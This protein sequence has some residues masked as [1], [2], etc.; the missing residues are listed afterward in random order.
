MASYYVT[1]S[2]T[3]DGTGADAANTMS[4]SLFN[5]I[6]SFAAG[7]EVL[8]SGAFSTEIDI[9]L[10]GTTLKQSSIYSPSAITDYLGQ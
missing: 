8:F 6:S 7:D 9:R 2:G 1:Q 10:G 3:G 4:V 5:V